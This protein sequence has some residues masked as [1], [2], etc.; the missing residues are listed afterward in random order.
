LVIFSFGAGGRDLS[1]L[2]RV[3]DEKAGMESTVW[4]VLSGSV[5]RNTVLEHVLYM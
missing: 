4:H 2:S 5:W 3:I 1:W